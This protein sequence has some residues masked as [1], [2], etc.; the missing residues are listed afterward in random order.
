MAQA[1]ISRSYGR[2]ELD[3]GLAIAAFRDCFFAPVAPDADPATIQRFEGRLGRKSAADVSLRYESPESM[4]AAADAGVAEFELQVA[5]ADYKDTV[6]FTKSMRWSDSS[7]SAEC[8]EDRLQAVQDLVAR[9]EQTLGI[10]PF[11]EGDLPKTCQIDSEFVTS[12]FNAAEF[13]SAWQAHLAS[14]ATPH[15]RFRG[16]VAERGQES[17]ERTY[18]DIGHLNSALPS[19]IARYRLTAHGGKADNIT[20]TAEMT[21]TNDRFRIYVNVSGPIEMEGRL[22]DGV[23]AFAAA[24]SLT[25]SRNEPHQT[26]TAG[27][28]RV[29]FTREAMDKAWFELLCTE[30][31]RLVPAPYYAAGSISTE[32]DT[33]GEMKRDGLPVFR[34]AAIDNWGSIVWASMS[35]SGNP[36]QV[37][38]GFDPRRDLI[39]LT[40]KAFD[41]DKAAEVFAELEQRLALQ[42]L[43]ESAYDFV[44]SRANFKVPVWNAKLFASTVKDLIENFISPR[45]VMVRSY[46]TLRGENGSAVTSYSQFDKYLEDIAKVSDSVLEATSIR[47]Q[48]PRGAEIAF[49]IEGEPRLLQVASSLPLAVFDSVRNAVR[50]QLKVKPVTVKGDSDATENAP[51]TLLQQIRSNEGFGGWLLSA[52][53][54]AAIGT[55]ITFLVGRAV[56]SDKVEIISPASTNDQPVEVQAGCIKVVFQLTH[57]TWFKDDLD[58]ASVTGDINLLSANGS[59]IGVARARTSP[60]TILIPP[61]DWVLFVYLPAEKRR[62]ETVH[63]KAVNPDFDKHETEYLKA[64]GPRLQ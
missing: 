47:A 54:G 16:T 4:L 18:D 38:V 42:R 59:S 12:T 34:R 22:R 64:C 57:D 55:I 40:V 14:L 49:T 63:V 5:S 15:G 25:P 61:G 41:E 32:H 27:D 37:T 10:E 17:L 19:D 21:L 7:L 9:F 23:A 39:N 44:K 52:V 31:E 43:T 58:E 35:V 48:G 46:I 36:Y 45:P 8:T 1:R 6:R 60:S 56:G 29:Y 3:V 30:M 62:S 13:R 11:V 2:V 28:T 51:K 53:L 50:Q 33:E 20:A 26:P 24:A